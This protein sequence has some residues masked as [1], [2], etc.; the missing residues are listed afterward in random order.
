MSFR[1]KN[2][3]LVHSSDYKDLL[4]ILKDGSS[5]T[6]RPAAQRLLV[7][8]RHPLD[9]RTAL[10]PV[11][12]ILLDSFSGPTEHRKVRKRLLLASIFVFPIMAWSMELEIS[13]IRELSGDISALDEFNLK[14]LHG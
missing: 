13:S 11:V 7:A 1:P 14:D 3:G 10:A 8:I 5:G 6:Q 9:E 2:L 12:A 4:I